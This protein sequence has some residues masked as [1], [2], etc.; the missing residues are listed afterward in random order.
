MDSFLNSHCHFN[1]EHS[2]VIGIFTEETG[3]K[4]IVRK[5]DVLITDILCTIIYLL[6]CIQMLYIDNPVG[7]GYSFVRDEDGLST[8][9][10]QVAD[11]LYEAML[12]FFRLF[13]YKDND[14]YITGKLIII[15]NYSRFLKL[16]GTNLHEPMCPNILSLS[17]RWDNRLIGTNCWNC[18]PIKWSRL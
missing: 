3:Y 11:N 10:N 18:V 7:T 12:Q 5:R 17:V 2:Y 14:F 4:N 6:H 1:S 13:G 8:N 15:I 16:I 9:E